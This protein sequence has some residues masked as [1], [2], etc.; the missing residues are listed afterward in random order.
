MIIRRR[1][2]V[3]QRRWPAFDPHSGQL[4]P[5]RHI[6]HRKYTPPEQSV[7]R[8]P[9]IVRRKISN[10]FS[11]VPYVVDTK[12]GP[13]HTPGPQAGQFPPGVDKGRSE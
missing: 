6:A 13:F 2:T 12:A 1:A 10:E 3:I 9:E 11:G 8:H 4:L 5:A 7:F